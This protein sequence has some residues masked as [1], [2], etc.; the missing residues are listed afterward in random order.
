M[1]FSIR[2]LPWQVIPVKT[3]RG[4]FGGDHISL[5]VGK[6]EKANRIFIIPRMINCKRSKFFFLPILQLIL[7]QLNPHEN[8]CQ[9]GNKQISKLSF[10]LAH[11]SW[12]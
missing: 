1:Y 4:K 3:G 7:H 11:I 12:L 2:G 10:V 9:I 5:W 8:K 6:Y